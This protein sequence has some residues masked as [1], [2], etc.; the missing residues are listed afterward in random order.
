MYKLK[1]ILLIVILILF[2]FHLFSQSWEEMQSLASPTGFPVM[3]AANGNIYLL[4]GTQGT[5]A[6]TFE[7]NPG[8]N[9]WIEKAPISSGTIYAS[10]VEVGGK[11]YI[12]GGLQSNQKTDLHYIY[13]PVSDEITNGSALLTPR[14]YHSA[15]TVNGKIYLIGGQNGDG[16][17]EWYF[18]EYNPDTDQW[19]RKEDT[20]HNQA[21]YCG[22]VGLNGK[23][24]RIAGGRWNVPTDYFDEYNPET[25]SWTSLDPF[26]ITC[27]APTA[28]TLEDKIYVMGGYN[29]EHKIDS[30]YTYY[31]SSKM[32][33]LSFVKL[34]EPL[35]YHKAVVLDG[36]IYVYT[37]DESTAKGRLWR[38]KFGSVGIKS[39]ETTN[40]MIIS[41]TPNPNNGQISISLSETTNFINKLEIFDLMGN[42]VFR[43]EINTNNAAKIKINISELTSGSYFLKVEAGNNIISKKFIKE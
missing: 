15:A 4:S 14:G 9:A 24:Y 20:P 13:D 17:T 8:S 27:H 31:P 11:I 3:A 34:P 16:T 43:N 32:W 42:C 29:S 7:Y 10:G 1:F 2:P 25:D 18:D 35:A 26:P 6:K 39:N 36:Y 40:E 28:V 38:Y 33:V 5:S 41:I 12:M 21:W 22:A 23:F 30:I 19:T 37:K